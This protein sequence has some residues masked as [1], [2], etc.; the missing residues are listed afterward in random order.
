MVRKIKRNIDRKSVDQVRQEKF[1]EA[2]KGFKKILIAFSGGLLLV[3]AA[4]FATRI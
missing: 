3:T 4:I 1:N 2:N